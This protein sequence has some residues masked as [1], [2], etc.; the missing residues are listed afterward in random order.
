MCGAIITTVLVH[1]SIKLPSLCE[2]VVALHARGCGAATKGCSTLHPTGV[3]FDLSLRPE[4]SLE[5]PKENWSTEVHDE[6]PLLRMGRR[7]SAGSSRSSRR[8]K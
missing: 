7:G 6:C 4:F 8:M 2:H 5:L 1:T 3:N